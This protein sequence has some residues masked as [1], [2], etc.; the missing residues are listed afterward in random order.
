M[1]VIVCDLCGGKLIIGANGTATCE[2]CGVEYSLERMKEK[3]QEL[4]GIKSVDNSKKIENY[5][6]L[7]ESA[8]D[9]NNLAEAESYANRILEVDPQ[10]YAAW[11]IKGKSAGWQS[12]Q[13]NNRVMESA[14]AFS[15]AIT[16]A[17]QDVKEQ[18][19]DELVNELR[20]LLIKMV[21]FQGEKFA[22]RPKDAGTDKKKFSRDIAA[23]YSAVEKFIK[24]S[25][26]DIS[27]EEIS[28]L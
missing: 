16:N 3:Y 10:N 7:A 20:N 12:D 13:Q 5:L 14:V 24:Q 8:C 28:C 4:H 9:A 22:K 23:S 6:E 25:G 2:G 17:P 15:K 1:A 27:F 11:I 18:I 21:S 19:T 26:A